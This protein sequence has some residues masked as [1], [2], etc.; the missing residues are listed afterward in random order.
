MIL[1]YKVNE[2]KNLPAKV[3]SRLTVK[4]GDA[5]TRRR[6]KKLMEILR[7][8]VGRLGTIAA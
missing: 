6:M 8:G 2:L 1:R 4:V 3:R 7:K 5:K